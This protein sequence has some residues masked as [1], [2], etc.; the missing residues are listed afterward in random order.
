MLRCFG[1]PGFDFDLEVIGLESSSDG[2][3]FPGFDFDLDVIGLESSSGGFTFS[4]VLALVT[5][6]PESLVDLKCH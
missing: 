5:G 4:G 3:D 6:P 1:F 2:F